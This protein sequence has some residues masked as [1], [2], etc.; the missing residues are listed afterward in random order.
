MNGE[1]SELEHLLDAAELLRA[2]QARR[3]AIAQFHNEEALFADGRM[4]AFRGRYNGAAVVLTLFHGEGHVDR[5]RRRKR[6]FDRLE[7]AL[8]DGRFRI[9]PLVAAWPGEGITMT[10]EVTGRGLDAEIA[11]AEPAGRDALVGE[12]GEW[13]ATVLAGAHRQAV[14]GG[15]HW[16]RNAARQLAR[17]GG[18]EDRALARTLGTRLEA[19]LP[20]VTGTTVTQALIHGDFRPCNLVRSS[21]ALC[22]IGM[23]GAQWMPVARDLARF[24]V[25]LHLT[26]PRPGGRRA[27]GIDA[28]D[29]DALSA[30]LALL[31]RRERAR[32][33]PFFIGVELA[34][35]FAQGAQEP[36]RSEALCAAVAHF[37][38][39]NGLPLL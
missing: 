20:T 28:G 12:A 23:A 10:A 13:L 31:E 33:L 17:V 14:F 8:A 35:S 29:L 32:L 24:L 7:T 3:P 16:V 21:E 38:D 2:I 22:G 19:L 9:A 34:D 18:A 1:L 11:A 37:L 36:G 5:T 4:A 30:P 26:H 25:D 6:E 27:F 15:R 39:G